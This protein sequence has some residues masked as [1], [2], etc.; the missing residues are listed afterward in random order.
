METLNLIFVMMI[1][2]SLVSLNQI[3]STAVKNNNDYPKLFKRGQI[4]T[5]K[6][7][8]VLLRNPKVTSAS[9]SENENDSFISKHFKMLE[10]FGISVVREGSVYAASA[11]TPGV[12]VDL[13]TP[14]GLPAYTAKLTKYIVKYLLNLPEVLTVEEDSKV[15]CADA[16][17]AQNNPPPVILS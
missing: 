9:V 16:Q 3:E 17:N 1:I 2:L 10:R 15:Y 7:Y 11:D 13:S 4:L 8:L 14:G 6:K 12:V 5:S